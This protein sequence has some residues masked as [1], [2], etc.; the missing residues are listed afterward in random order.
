MNNNCDEV[1]S[2]NENKFK[3]I[4]KLMIKLNGSKNN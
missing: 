4:K 2:L 1:F 3:N